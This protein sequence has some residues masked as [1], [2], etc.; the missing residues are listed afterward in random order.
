MTLP[1]FKCIEDNM[2]A[3]IVILSAG[4]SHRL[5]VA[6][7]QVEL[8]GQ[9]LL[10]RACKLASRFALRTS[11]QL[12][13]LVVVGP[14][15]DQDRHALATCSDVEII[16]NPHWQQG[17][18]A[19]ISTAIQAR[20]NSA[21]LLLLLVDQYRVQVRDLLRLHEKWQQQPTDPVAATYAGTIGPPVIWPSRYFSPLMAQ[22][23]A[24]KTLLQSVRHQRVGIPAA[25][26]DLD[27]TQD[28]QQLRNFEREGSSDCK[29]DGD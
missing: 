20:A 7:Q 10:L 2:N 26:T 8:F 5:G 13:P 21:G 1:V 6:K 29:V 4:A 9:P 27:V 25:A 24:A 14:Y 12:P 23:G 19:T 18:P 11:A 22:S 28:L 3:D 17:L 15:A 16:D